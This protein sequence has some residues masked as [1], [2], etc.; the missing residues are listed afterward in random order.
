MKLL[1]NIFILIF[2]IFVFFWILKKRNNF[3]NTN[4][5]YWKSNYYFYWS[6]KNIIINLTFKLL[7]AK[8]M[9]FVH[10]S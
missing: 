9:K 4:N 6:I 1:E 10:F 3:K 5:N 2:E 7:N 8:Y